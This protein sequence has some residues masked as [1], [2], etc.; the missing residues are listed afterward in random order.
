MALTIAVGFGAT[1]HR[2]A[3]KHHDATSRRAK[4]RWRRP[5]KG[6]SEI[7]FTIVSSA[8]RWSPC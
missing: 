7:G 6:A 5:S 1:R 3:G 8:S 2:D 4:D